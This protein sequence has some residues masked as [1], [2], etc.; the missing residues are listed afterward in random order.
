MSSGMEGY[1]A[2]RLRMTLAFGRLFELEFCTHGGSIGEAEDDDLAV[3]A[4]HR[5]GMDHS[6]VEVSGEYVETLAPYPFPTLVLAR[7]VAS[8]LASSSSSESPI[9]CLVSG[10]P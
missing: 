4:A 5:D 1:G 3:F 2:Y 8:S 10:M 6:S 9:C 7:S